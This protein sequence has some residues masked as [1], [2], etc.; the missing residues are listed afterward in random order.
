MPPLLPNPPS[1]WEG[2]WGFLACVVDIMAD[3]QAI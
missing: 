3:R 2:V 1:Q